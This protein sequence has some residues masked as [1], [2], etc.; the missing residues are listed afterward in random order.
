M[1]SCRKTGRKTQVG[2]AISSYYRIV[3]I[4]EV[5]DF[6]EAITFEINVF[7]G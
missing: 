4:G 6:T 2:E 5:R 7:G 1:S 3:C